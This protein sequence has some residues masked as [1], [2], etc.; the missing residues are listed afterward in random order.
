MPAEPLLEAAPPSPIAKFELTGPQAL[1]AVVA[2]NTLTPDV[3]A[4]PAETNTAPLSA[5]ESWEIPP[6]PDRKPTVRET[7]RKLQA[8]ARPDAPLREE[9]PRERPQLRAQ[10][11]PPPSE[12]P[13]RTPRISAPADVLA[14]GL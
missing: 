9:R 11:K 6:I 5:V 1:P 14:G 12:T 4:R 10:Q 8:E 2:V 3:T 7:D 13:A